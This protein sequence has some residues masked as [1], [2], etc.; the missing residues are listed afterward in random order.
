[1]TI[2]ETTPRITSVVFKGLDNLTLPFASH[3]F[4]ASDL[5][6]D[7]PGRLM[8]NND[9]KYFVKSVT[10]LEPPDRNIAIARTSSGG[11]FQGVTTE[12]REV[13]VLLGL[14]PDWDAGE[15]PAL[16]RQNLYTMLEPGY[17]PR[18]DIQLWAGDT[19]QF[20][21]FA[22]V[23]K[24]EASI[25]DANPAC[26]MT[27][28]TL[29]ETF[30]AM[31]RKTYNPGNLSEKH[32]SIYNPGTAQT[33]FQFAVR[34][35]GTMNGWSIKQA[36]NQKIGMKFDM[37]FHGG[38]VLAVSTIP[39]QKYVHWSKH[40]GKVQNVL[41]ILTSDSEWLQLHPGQNHFVVPKK[42]FLWDWKGQLSFTP[43]YWGI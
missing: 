13:V 19:A 21:E 5:D 37:T 10:G 30:R 24:F 16:L 32:P 11:K 29:N 20:H 7:L 34:F 43:K 41:G 35:D 39:G 36:G 2:L 33:G 23:D 8:A 31:K 6:L 22:Y 40:R 4:Q 18:V 9:Q 27:F 26:Q 38:D 1:M 42:A 25:W 12:D 28:V 3:V 15:T 17:D 14:N